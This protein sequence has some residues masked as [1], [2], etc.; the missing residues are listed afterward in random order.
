MKWD[1]GINWPKTGGGASGL[2]PKPRPPAEPVEFE[3]E[4]P[5]T[6]SEAPATPPPKKAKLSNPKWGKDKGLFDEKIEATVDGDL[7]PEL[8]HLTKVH[9]T[10]FAI[11]P[12]GS[13]ERID[14]KDGYLNEGK[15]KIEFE[16]WTPKY[17]NKTGHALKKAEYY[18]T[19]QA[20]GWG[21]VEVGFTP[22]PDQAALARS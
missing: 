11:L 1:D 7:P 19:G 13:T 21:G 9:F 20:S 2:K 3:P 12:D 18:F 10:L 8:S 6:T 16:L 17:R 14:A 15:A 22:G 5:A 4:A